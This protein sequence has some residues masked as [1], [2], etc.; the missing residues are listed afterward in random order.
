M[1]WFKKGLFYCSLLLLSFFFFFFL[2]KDLKKS[3]L[4]T[5]KDR[6]NLVFL[7]ENPLFYSFDL[8]DGSNYMVVFFPDLKATI[9]VVMVNIV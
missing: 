6:L 1:V 4:F 7:Q 2:I 3:Y 5:Q 8:K 9:R